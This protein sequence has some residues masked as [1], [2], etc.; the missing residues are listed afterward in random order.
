MDCFDFLIY[1]KKLCI[2]PTSSKVSEQL[3]KITGSSFLHNCML[4]FPVWAGIKYRESKNQN[5]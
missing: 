3:T 2:H 4:I 1:Y 5:I